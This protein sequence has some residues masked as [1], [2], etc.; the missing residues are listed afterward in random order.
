MAETNPGTYAAKLNKAEQVLRSALEEFHPAITIASSF[1]M[2]DVALMYMASKMRPDAHIFAIDTGRLNEE[3]YQCAELAKAVTGL[4]VEWLFPRFEGVEKLERE[5]GLFSF[6]T[7]LDARHECCQ[8]R[9]VE[10]LTRALKE[11]RAWITGLRRAQNVTRSDLS[12]VEIDAAHDGIT[13]VNPLLEWE[14]KDLRRYVAENK[15]PYSTLYDQGYASI[16]CAPCT[17]AIAPGEHVRAGRWWWES[18]VQKE[19]GLHVSSNVK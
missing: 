17:R 12:Y 2:E 10:P 13:K 16:G 19:C 5:K 4:R 11:Q 18:G 9:K 3:T 1:S 15:V 6:R 7:S 8:V 14:E